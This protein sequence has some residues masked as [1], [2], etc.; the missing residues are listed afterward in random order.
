MGAGNAWTALRRAP[1]RFLVSR[2]PWLSL[3]YLAGSAIIGLALI[4]VTVFAFLLLPLWALVIGALERRRT[5]LV[6][7]P[8][9]QSGHARVPESERHHWLSIRVSEAATWREALAY[10]VDLVFGLTVLVLLFFQGVAVVAL[11]MVAYAGIT[12]PTPTQFFGNLTG[13]M[14]PTNWWPVLLV[15]VALFCVLGYA[16][17]LAAATQASFLRVL[18]GPR[19]QELAQNVERLERSRR[20]LLESS[21]AE[22]RRIER[23]L[24]DGAQQELIA[25]GARLGMI[26]L[27]ADELAARGAD[28]TELVQAINN[29]N[30]QAEQAMT[31]L[32]N[33]ARGIHPS[34][35]T[36]HGLDVALEELAERC[37]VPV[38]M[39]L[40]ETG[41]LPPT[42]ETAAYY[43]T[44]EALNNVAKHA[45]ATTV[46]V[47]THTDDTHFSICITDD[48][49]G[50]ADEAAGS[51]LQG[52]RARAEALNGHFAVSSPLGGATVIR[53]ELPL[54]TVEGGTCES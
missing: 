43:F 20:A 40:G 34:V 17:T 44:A 18:C 47:Q 35:L 52:L 6:G 32:R 24:H 28:T 14:T 42:I 54:T 29:A 23:D 51:G 3:L 9:Q 13:V 7:F 37:R 12:G 1:W 8:L 2:W 5:T 38:S 26:G 15:A 53:M 11:G 49:Q 30:E 48:G 39:R 25:L 46:T 4:P 41:R 22:R 31:T 33:T 16:N 21:E 50:G 27:E 45:A 10:L 19:S 36:D